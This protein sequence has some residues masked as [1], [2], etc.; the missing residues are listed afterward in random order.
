MQIIQLMSGEHDV[1]KLLELMM[2]ASYSLVHA[3]RSNVC[4]SLSPSEWVSWQDRIS[5][6]SVDNLAGTIGRST[7][8][9]LCSASHNM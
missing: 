5:M 4:R 8:L 6:F 7:S 9:P 1:R 3:V 2:Q